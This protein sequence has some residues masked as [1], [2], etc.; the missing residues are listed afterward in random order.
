[1]AE[2]GAVVLLLGWLQE[3]SF[4]FSSAVFPR[5][6]TE[7]VTAVL[8]DGF[9]LPP[10]PGEGLLAAAGLVLGEKGRSVGVQS[11]CR[12]AFGYRGISSGRWLP[13]LCAE[14]L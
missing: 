2:K 10:A 11:C 14:T 3:S 7:E 4:S 6:F 9:L 8:A 12:V 5:V 13:A 1:M